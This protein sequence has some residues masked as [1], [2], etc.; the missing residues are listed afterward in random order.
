MWFL[1]YF[2]K[3]KI[4]FYIIFNEQYSTSHFLSLY[5]YFIYKIITVQPTLDKLS[6]N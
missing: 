4:I 1:E 2:S 5:T 3:I 6:K